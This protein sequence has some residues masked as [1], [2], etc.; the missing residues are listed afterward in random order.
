MTVTVGGAS[1][2]SAVDRFDY[3]TFPFVTAVTANSGP[4]TGGQQV[5]VMGTNLANPTSV[6]FGTTAATIVS[7]TATTVTVTSPAGT[8][9]ARSTL[10]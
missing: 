6:N 7:S 9:G 1:G 8:L 3:G 5:T 10:R 2:T 4:T